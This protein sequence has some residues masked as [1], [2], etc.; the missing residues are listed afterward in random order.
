MY[1]APPARANAPAGANDVALGWSPIR[2]ND[3]AWPL[4]DC[5]AN[6]SAWQAA[7]A[8]APRYEPGGWS[9]T[10]SGCANSRS[11]AHVTSGSVQIRVRFPGHQLAGNVS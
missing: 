3:R 9:N 8:P 10:S 7:Q 6:C 5:C 1:F 11:E 4:I 2:C